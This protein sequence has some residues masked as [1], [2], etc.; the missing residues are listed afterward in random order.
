MTDLAL[1]PIARTIHPITTAVLYAKEARKY[2]RISAGEFHR[3]VSEGILVRRVHVRGKRPFFLKHE[4][5]AYLESTPRYTIQPR[6]S[7]SN[8]TERGI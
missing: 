8:A 2:L 1:V 5:D 6:E 3:L 7:S 4:L